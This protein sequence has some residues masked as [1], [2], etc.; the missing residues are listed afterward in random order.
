MRNVINL[1][2]ILI[3]FLLK[4]II[5]N[6]QDCDQIIK[7]NQ[8]SGNNYNYISK[9][10]VHFKQGFSY[11]PTGSNS[12]KAS[13]AP[14]HICELNEQHIVEGYDSQNPYQH[15]INLPVGN[16][17]GVAG[18]SATGAATYT[19]PIYVIPG[20]AGM[21]PSI[22]IVYNSQSNN[23]ILGQGWHVSGLSAIS[24]VSNSYYNDGYFEAIKF[25]NATT[26]K[27]RYAIRYALDGNRLVCTSETYGQN[28]SIYRT[29]LETFS[30]IN[31]NNDKFLVYSKDGYISHYGSTN[32]SKMK[33]VSGNNSKTYNW[34]ID[35]I[36][37]RLGNY[38][39]YEYYEHGGERH[40]KKI[41]YTGTSDFGPYNTIEFFY[42]ERDDNIFG[43][44]SGTEVK[45]TLLLNR[46]DVKHNGG[47]AKKY[48]FKY[49]IEENEPAK[50][51]EIVEYGS[52]GTYLNSTV[53]E[54]GANGGRPINT[55]GSSFS[56]LPNS[57][58]TSPSDDYLSGDYNCDGLRDFVCVSNFKEIAN[59]TRSYLV[60]FINNGDN[61]FSKLEQCL[62][63][64]DFYSV[65][66]GDF[67]N[68]GYD[69]LMLVNQTN[70]ET[71]KFV[72]N[73]S[74]WTSIHYAEKLT[75]D[76]GLRAFYSGNFY[77]NGKKSKLVVQKNQYASSLIFES[78]M[79]SYDSLG[80]NILGTVMLKYHNYSDNKIKFTP[81]PLDFDGDGV[82][83]FINIDNGTLNIYE[84]NRTTRTLGILY[85]IPGSIID[86][87]S[88]LIAPTG[89]KFGD[90][91][92][93]GKTD[94]MVKQWD[95]RL[96]EWK[97]Y[98]SDGTKFIEKGVF[99]P[100][101]PYSQLYLV[102]LNGDGKDDI[103]DSYGIYTMRIET[104]ISNG[105]GVFVAKDSI[106]TYNNGDVVDRL[107]F[108]DFNGDGAIDFVFGQTQ[109]SI[110]Y[111]N[112][113]GKNRMVKK[114]TDGFKN[115][116]EFSYTT[117]TK[118]N[119]DMN[120]SVST[121]YS[122]MNTY[123]LTAPL[124][125]VNSLKQS[126]GL[127]G[128]SALSTTTYTY[129]NGRQ[130]C[131]GKGFLGFESICESNATSNL[132]KCTTNIFNYT[133]NI[134]EKTTVQ[135]GVL[136][137]GGT[138][139]SQYNEVYIK[140]MNSNK[141]SW[142]AVVPVKQI[143]TNYIRNC[144]NTTT[145]TYTYQNLNS[146][147]FFGNLSSTKEDYMSCYEITTEY[148][149]YVSSGSWCVSKPGVIKTTRKQSGYNTNFVTKKT[150][151]YNSNGTIYQIIS[152]SDPSGGKPLTESFTY[153]THGNITNKLTI[154]ISG[155]GSASTQ[156]SQ[157]FEYGSYSR[158]ITLNRDD[159]TGLFETSEYEPLFGNV[160]KR[161]DRN[162][163]I[164]IYE[165]D[166]FGNP[167]KIHSPQRHVIETK[168]IWENTVQNNMAYSVLTTAPGKPET[169]VWYDILGR[170]VKT[171]TGFYN[172]N[173]VTEKQY[174]ADGTLYKESIPHFSTV[175][176]S[177]W[178][179]YTYDNLKRITKVSALS[180]N[181]NY[182]YGTANE[183]INYPDGTYRTTNTNPAGQV[184][185]ISSTEGSIAYL[186]H[187][188]GQPRKITANGV[189]TSMEY[190]SY[191]NQTALVD[192]NAGRTEYEYN[193][194]GELIKQ[195][196][197]KQDYFK[198]EYDNAGR[199]TT[200]IC[201]NSA[202]TK[203]YI[204]YNT[205]IAK[206]RLQNEIMYNTY[207]E[208]TYDTYGN[209]TCMKEYINGTILNHYYTYDQYNNL[210]TYTY[211]SGFKI[212]NTY[213]NSGYLTKVNEEL[214]AVATVWELTG[215]S[216]INEMGQF[217]NYKLG[218]NNINV[219]Y[220]Y[221]TYYELTRI[222]TGNIFDY[223][224]THN[225]TKSTLT[226]RKDNKTSKQEN[227]TY[228]GIGR[229]K[230]WQ[231]SGQLQ[232]SITYDMS[233]GN[234]GNIIEKSD[235]GVYT[236]N[237]A[238]PHAVKNVSGDNIFGLQ[239]VNPQ[240]ITY[241]PLHKASQIR[242][243]T[244]IH[245]YDILYGPDS[246]RKRTML[247]NNNSL[248]VTKYYSGM[249]EKEVI[250][251]GD[252]KEIHYIA[253]GSGIVAAHIRTN[254]NAQTGTTYYMAKDHLGSVMAVT[255]KDQNIVQSHSY[256]AWGNMRNP[257]TWEYDSV[258]TDFVVNMGYTGHEHLPKF[259]L[260]NMNGRMYD[261]VIGRMLSPDNYVQAPGNAQNYNRYSYCL[262]NPLK[263][264]DPSGEFIQYIIGA[265]VGGVN[266]YMMADA[267]GH[268]GW[269]K[270]WYT[271]G[272]AA[273]G[274]AT[275][276][277][278]T[279]ISSSVSGAGGVIL[280]GTAA[281]AVNAGGFNTLSNAANGNNLASGLGRSMIFG[282]VSGAAGSGIS[283]AIGGGWGAFAGGT[284]SNLTNQGL[285]FMAYKNG[286]IDNFK[287][288]WVSPLLSGGLSAG[289]YHINLSYHYKSGDIKA[290]TGWSYKQFA[291]NM[292][293]TQRS[294][295]WNTEAK[296]ITNNRGNFNVA[297]LGSEN[298]VS[299]RG[300]D[301]IGATS[302]YHTHQDWGYNLVHGEGFS[303]CNP[304]LPF[305]YQSDEGARTIL[306]MIGGQH[307]PMYLGTK[308]GHI[309]YMNGNFSF[310]KINNFNFSRIF[311][312][313]Y[314]YW[315]Y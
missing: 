304:D 288:S 50:L 6:A 87:D 286:Y 77:G 27:D 251:G 270:F 208:Y 258:N 190:D 139:S 65:Y 248:A 86:F 278:G 84:F 311:A 262:N 89:F 53:I 45:Q 102:D 113:D 195:T 48:V 39:N 46:I 283:G 263:F 144:E 56:F 159:Y 255:D 235:V 233:D 181:T 230:T 82:T 118:Q 189:E 126:T 303:M 19:I 15:D 92:G 164:T 171:M 5:T 104:N 250:S 264:T 155:E 312:P 284:V 200:E 203:T 187:S 105:D 121:N 152:D 301:F 74:S 180:L 267:T 1:L 163:N 22:S 23:G 213:N 217:L 75:P 140:Q 239:S 204:Y 143:S 186:Y 18:V 209:V 191:G 149:G 83:D 241:N 252:T 156:R 305:D 130:H 58:T 193:A 201:R 172:K 293:Y 198:F 253:G 47:M 62:S 122:I 91:N 257:Q 231:T 234:K 177:K 310:D 128:T 202:F 72:W 228:D 174:N 290:A 315:L 4:V 7:S 146:G 249:Y 306:N 71:Y 272:G 150:I 93:D 73:G 308:E 106:T 268:K 142:I 271:L 114:I 97:I 154:G 14:Y 10:A 127:T 197:A 205:G 8:H 297:K 274:A 95:S 30:N 225:H 179:T 111:Y 173:V 145:T 28:N 63:D 295:F 194:F 125:V 280:A 242:E 212:K 256:D 218:P 124:S 221:N 254:G 260:I 13:T 247:Y 298:S 110:C 35:K 261:P 51:S 3:L 294:M 109:A 26:P 94:L 107:T 37:D 24:M 287:F 96:K 147:T 40:I 223:S 108:D 165:Y 103:V 220:T 141:P 137:P 59:K 120:F 29:E 78:I 123:L 101:D 226:T 133:H 210:D 192:A 214:P 302:S 21:E 289:I 216:Y 184:T 207:K 273:I 132:Y 31:Y 117:I 157:S 232:Q 276:G 119:R 307:I 162:G 138:I 244:N 2:L 240:Y 20:T 98:V 70:A 300:V 54:W 112:K 52:D 158:F 42:S 296:T 229:L 34:L 168:S 115:I 211:P 243:G 55:I 309:W 17:P 166:G 80:N 169:R 25:D 282:G 227:F 148:S 9:E 170:E 135:V 292:T 281:G 206:G 90:V 285:N 238:K 236:Y 85:T 188:T 49:K 131:E 175:S 76:G 67:D 153:D 16:I 43:Y 41:S 134:V 176:A 279:A 160:V 299:A 68:D 266:G 199:I 314:N 11:K 61:T 151:L 269:N 275:A 129:R 259:G 88:F 69:E 12:L 167:T 136:Q 79:I 100:K 60:T 277:I 116:N 245:R 44:I 38:I 183:T 291:K 81:I 57:T 246:E 178:K 66:S 265:V 182:S 219:S 99:F 224:Y 215:S 237:S 64:K 185:G 36:E 161:T 222:I 32:G 196:D 313:Y 33:I